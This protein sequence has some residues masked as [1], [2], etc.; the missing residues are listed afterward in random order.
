MIT[1][2]DSGGRIVIP[3]TL[4]ERFGL[5]PGQEVEVVENDGVITVTPRY[6]LSRVEQRDGVFV[7]VT[8]APPAAGVDAEATR[9]VLEA[10]R[11]R[12]A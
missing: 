12:R 2:I 5:H 9:E 3:K 11:E 6:P 10:V 1:T 7:A 4:R 8:D